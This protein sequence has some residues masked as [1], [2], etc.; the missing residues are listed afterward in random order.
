LSTPALLLRQFG[1]DRL[2]VPNVQGAMTLTAEFAF[3]ETKTITFVAG[4][5]VALTARPSRRALAV[6]DRELR[7]TAKIS[8]PRTSQRTRSSLAERMRWMANARIACTLRSQGLPALQKLVELGQSIAACSSLEEAQALGRLVASESQLALG[9]VAG[10][11]AVG[12]PEG[13]GA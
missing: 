9:G 13:I 10:P 7:R 5:N 2:T 11:V 3:I 12:Q 6:A 8:F 4:P 1:D